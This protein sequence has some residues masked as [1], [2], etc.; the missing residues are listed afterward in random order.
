VDV[1]DLEA[2]WSVIRNMQVRGKQSKRR[3]RQ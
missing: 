3:K 1:P 2:A